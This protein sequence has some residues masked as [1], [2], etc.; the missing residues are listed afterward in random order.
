M[1]TIKCYAA[2]PQHEKKRTYFNIRFSN[3]WI[4]LL[5][6][7]NFNKNNRYWTTWGKVEKSVFGNAFL[8]MCGF[9][10]WEKARGLY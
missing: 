1:K 3:S 9:L 6:Q 7:N 4:W 8:K 2:S 10:K 5:N